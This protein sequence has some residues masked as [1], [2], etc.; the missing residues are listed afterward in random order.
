VKNDEVNHPKTNLAEDGSIR[1]LT[2]GLLN[3]NWL[4]VANEVGER[5]AISYYPVASCIV[6]KE[7]MDSVA[8]ENKKAYKI[9]EK[10]LGKDWQKDLMQKWIV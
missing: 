6:S 2:Y 8:I 7:L 3:M 10:R 9:I 1:I 5:Y 4:H